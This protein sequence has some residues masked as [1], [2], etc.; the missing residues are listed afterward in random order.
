MAKLENASPVVKKTARINHQ[1]LKRMA[2]MTHK[3][4]I[5]AAAAVLALAI[6][7]CS[8]TNSSTTSTTTGSPS[9][10]SSALG[11]PVTP[12]QHVIVIFGEN[13]SYDHYFGTYPSVGYSAAN[14]GDAKEID[15]TNFPS[16]ATAP[17]N[18]NLVTPLDTST[19]APIANPTLLTSNPNSAT[20]SGAT[21]N[22]VS[23]LNPFLLWNDQAATA[24]QNHSPKPEQTAYDN[25]LVDQ[26]PGSTGSTASASG[27]PVPVLVSSDTVAA[28]GKGQVMGYYDG[29]TVTALW[30]YAQ[31]YSMNDN[32]YTSQFGPSTP[33]A[34]NLISGQ[35]NGLSQTLNLIP[36][37]TGVQPGTCT[38]SASNSCTTSSSTAIPDG[39]GGFTLVGD[40]DP[41][42][43]VCSTGTVEVS[44]A[45]KNIGDLLN[46]QN[47]TWGWFSGGFNLSAQPNSN[48]S[49]GCNRNTPGTQ[50]NYETDP[51]YIQH[52][53]PFQY[54][55]STQNLQHLR[56]SSEYAI[57]SSYELDGKTPD[58]ANHQYDTA[59][60]FTALKEGNL[61]SVSFLK[62]PGYEDGHAGYS[63]P[64]DEQRF[65]VQVVSSVM[66]SPEW[67]STAII[68]TYDDS[69]GWYDHQMPP[70]LNPSS[71]ALV[72]SLSG[73]GSCTGVTGAD[74][75]Q[76]LTTA[77][78]PLL[79]NDGN[80]AQGRCGYGTRIPF[81]VISPYAKA[82]YVDHTLLDQ[83]SVIRFIEDNWLGGQRV[84][85]GGSFDTIAGSI[86]GM[87]SFAA[88]SP[89]DVQ[90][91]ADK[92]KLF[93]DPEKGIKLRAQQ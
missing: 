58:P 69:D 1:V 29:T 28:Q 61:P 24:D 68:I 83:S 19:W 27:G 14:A 64:I 71:S 90:Q 80:P 7:G 72:D 20:G 59:D 93:L 12:I 82:N 65:I 39:N 25:G 70:I 21:F 84:Q 52:H 42:G 86:E 92:R 26:F 74:S 55:A 67:A 30:N 33:G 13:N 47:V 85:A 18:N 81:V 11:T 5:P 88:T 63:D 9:G 36:G 89:N 43:D 57:G 60:F 53:E 78:T 51:D 46:A 6:A 54:Y 34:I 66:S 45:G 73:A 4:L 87:F 22:G 35:T 8:N 23:A 10:T 62:A 49:Y 91:Q 44:F 3:L 56:P 76:G 50:G 32:T 40:A 79:G 2:Y 38:P 17:A 48:G 37:T 16:T 31:A 41:I 15:L 75:Q 77:A